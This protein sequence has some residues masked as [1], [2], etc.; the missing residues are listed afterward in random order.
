MPDVIE[1]D[2]LVVGAGAAGMTITDALLSHSAASVTLIE[3]RHAPGGHWLD[4]YPFV[5]LHQPSAFYGVDSVPLG[6][7][8]ID[9][10]GL[11][12]GF[13]ET[14]NADELRAYFAHVMQEHF[15]PT[16]RV[17][18]F[19]CSDYVGG[20]GDSHH[21][22][23]HLT[24]E[25]Q[26]VRVKRKLV[27][28]GYLEGAIPATS[29]PPFEVDEG[30]QCIPAGDVA[31]LNERARPFVVI[32]AGKTALDTC[33]WLL[34]NGVPASSIR[35][36]K[37]RESWWLN[38][39]FHQ[40]HTFLPELYAGV[41]LQFQAMA[42]AKSID[43]LFLR[44]EAGGFALRVDPAVMPTMMRG[45][46]LSEVELALLRRIKDVVRLG[47]VRRIGR[48]NMVLDEGEVAMPEDAIYVH[49]AAAGLARPP[50][51]PIFEADRMTVQP[52]MWG[53]ASH[54]FALL[55]V[56]EATID[57]DEEKNRLCRPIHYWDQNADYL[58]AYMARL[59]SERARGSHPALAAWARE[60]RLNPLARL[61]EYSN[62]PTV[63]A[64]QGLLKRVA[65]AAMENMPKLLAGH[66]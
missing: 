11:N 59:A 25:R 10:G 64:T 36:V 7:D 28:T 5:R 6:K 66:S 41:G 49:C 40:P 43:D 16:G 4:A 2:Y 19:P 30:V 61:G 60:S 35:W 8:A 55:G 3:R 34:T 50:L 20:E 14:A 13:Y 27:D 44:L 15:L 24:G 18:F 47:R 45:A 48:G 17:R 65:P 38:R 21:F 53:F 51:R 22:V 12:A 39:R 26:E 58:T 63:V 31:R 62:H 23:S 32:G 54:Q 57:S 9:R 37:P 1:T 29:K 52:I 46:I 33:V 42:E 56:T